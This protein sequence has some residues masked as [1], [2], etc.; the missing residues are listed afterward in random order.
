MIKNLREQMAS[1]RKRKYEMLIRKRDDFLK[2]NSC[3][4]KERKE[5]EDKDRQDFKEYKLN[6]FPFTYGEQYVKKQ[7]KLKDVLKED[8]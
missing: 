6:F 5:K 3:Q 7:E 4:R 8:F 1:D 2:E